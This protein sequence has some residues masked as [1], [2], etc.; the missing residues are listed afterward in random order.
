MMSQSS[1]LCFGDSLTWGWVPTPHSVPT[2]RYPFAER[3]TGVMAGA[4]PGCVVVEEGLSART[5]TLDDPLDS[6]LNGG[7]YLPA[8]L[9]SHL[10]L[11]LVIIMLG[12][13][14]SKAIFQR[15]AQ[16]IAYGMN[17]LAGQVLGSAGGVGSVYPAPQLL[18]VAPP[19]LGEM[20]D[21]YFR[22]L[23]EGAHEKVAQLPALYGQLAA[24]LGVHFL[25]ANAFTGTDGIDGIHLTAEANRRLG[26]GIAAKVREILAGPGAGQTGA[27]GL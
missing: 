2:T 17:G 15:R 25:D 20:P 16:D 12:T 10:P 5:T 3:W 14:D 19:A 6:R 4:V 26:I 11:D 18:I 24:F 7:A 23:F 27:E 22:M 13:N 8:A 21:P 9:A 1:I